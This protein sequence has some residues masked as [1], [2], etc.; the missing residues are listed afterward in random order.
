MAFALRRRSLRLAA[1]WIGGRIVRV[2]RSS[3]IGLR[4]RFRPDRVRPPLYEGTVIDDVLFGQPL[5][6]LMRGL[7]WSGQ[8]RTVDA[9]GISVVVVNWNTVDVLKVS[10]SA[11]RRYSPPGTELIVIDNGSTDGS[12][13]WLR[14]RPFGSRVVLLPVNVGHG[15]G[16]DIGFAL[17]RSPIVVTLDSD[18]FPYSDSWLDVLLEPVTNGGHV[19]AGIWGRRDR[20]HP[21]CAAFRRDAYYEAGISFANYAPFLD[22]RE[23]PV[24][25]ENSWDAGE[26]LFHRLGPERVH[27]FP[28]DRSTYGGLTMADVVYHHEGFTTMTMFEDDLR[29]ASTHGPAWTKAVNGLLGSGA[30]PEQGGS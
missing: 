25:L 13:E 12:R 10:L 20:L 28:A 18:A 5:H 8:R 27:L 19:A 11:I 15:R 21:A 22:R 29:D 26:L 6:L 3:G 24:F 23:E 1:R 30:L 16:L 17:A 9:S 2:L 4:R 7:R 14:S